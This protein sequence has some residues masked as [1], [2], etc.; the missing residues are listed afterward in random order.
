[1]GGNRKLLPEERRALAIADRDYHHWGFFRALLDAAHAYSR[2]DPR[3]AVNIVELALAVSE[4]LD[5]RAVGGDEAATDMRA[6]G[7]AILGNARRLAS[8]FQGAREAINEAWRLN[9]AGTGDP[10]ERAAI[11][12]FDASYI[13]MMGEFET[14]ESVL[15]EALKIYA[16]A[17]DQHMQGRILIQ[18]GDAVGY[19]NPERGIG[20]LKRAVELISVSREPRLELC[21]QHD[22]AHFLSDAGRPEEALALLDRSRPLY[23]QFPDDWTQQRLHWLEGKIARSLGHLD[24]AANIFRQVWEGFR[25]LDLHFP[26]V[27]VSIDLA[28]TYVAQGS[29]A[30]AA[31]LSAEVY[32]ILSAW[33]VSRHALSAWLILENAVALHQAEDL[34]GKIRSYFRRRW[35]NPAEFTGE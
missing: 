13:R 31:R 35:N 29:H 25:G 27:M 15:E 8:D 17:G 19:V 18:M 16:T 10:L 23:K 24:E 4:I 32:S 9:E 22:L 30:T 3:E 33:G 6:N 14:A 7:Y 21:A 28:E 12:S 20:H 11:I 5:V 1:M 34:F 2:T 26:L